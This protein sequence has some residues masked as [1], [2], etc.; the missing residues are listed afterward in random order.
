MKLSQFKRLILCYFVHCA[1]QSWWLRSRSIYFRKSRALIFYTPKVRF[2]A[3][4]HYFIVSKTHTFS[5]FIFRK[6]LSFKVQL[7]SNV[8][9]HNLLSSH[10]YFCHRLRHN[11]R[12]I[13][14]IWDNQ[15][16][17]CIPFLR[18][19]VGNS[20][21]IKIRAKVR[22]WFFT[23][24][25]VLLGVLIKVLVL[26]PRLWGNTFFITFASFILAAIPII[27]H[28]PTQRPFTLWLFATMYVTR[29]H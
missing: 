7:R 19:W 16:H 23:C 3:V 24:F 1:F 21:K 6:T 18:Y 25:Y 27:R 28:S 13:L 5:C 2:L 14:P 8:H 11:I 10:I 17:Y 15:I 9:Y 29:F 12:P 26:T 20:W 22:F 4:W